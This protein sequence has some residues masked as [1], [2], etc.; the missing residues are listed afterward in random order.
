MFDCLQPHGL[1][2]PYNSPEYWS[3][4]PFPS[5]GDLPSQGIKARSPALQADSLPSELPG[6]PIKLISPFK[7]LFEMAAMELFSPIGA[8][9]YAGVGNLSSQTR[10]GTRVS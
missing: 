8:V 4:L 5:P 10:D 6:K 7:K 9:W 1:Y 3:G 2:S